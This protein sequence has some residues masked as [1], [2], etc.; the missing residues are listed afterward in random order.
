MT[1]TAIIGATV[2]RYLII[3]IV[4]Y[5]LTALA[6][7]YLLRMMVETE[8]VKPNYRGAMIP[9]EAGA[10]FLLLLPVFIGCGLVLGLPEFTLVPT[11]A[12]LLVLLGMGLVGLLDDLVGTN[13]N[14]GFKGH[15]ISLVKTGK[16][17]SGCLKALFGA[18]LALVFV[19]VV[20]KFV[21]PERPLWWLI[22]DFLLVVLATNT[23][24]LFDLRP[25]RAGKVFLVAFVLI[26]VLGLVRVWDYLGL[27]LPVLAVFLCYFPY[28]LRATVMLGDVGS[29]PLGATLGVMMVLMWD[30]WLKILAVLGLIAIQL[31]AER[32]SFTEII[33]KFS[34]LTW[35]DD[36][37]RN[38]N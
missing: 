30:N 8:M 18:M 5:V 29:N 37:G 14:K 38:K 7:P 15:F 12:Y 6:L 4:C 28:D 1:T 20:G 21:W 9:A 25:G 3:F 19:V 16:L 13:E 26:V 27:F 22:V 10:V 34:W 2:L 35:F 33:A 17:T 23:I 36:L 24:N 32:F 11:L 31:V